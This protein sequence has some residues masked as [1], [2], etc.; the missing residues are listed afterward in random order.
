MIDL[1]ELSKDMTRFLREDQYFV[2]L[3]ILSNRKA[4]STDRPKD[5]A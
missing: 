1:I 4:L 2:T 3:N 5:P